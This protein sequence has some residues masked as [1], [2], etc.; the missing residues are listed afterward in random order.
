MYLIKCEMEEMILLQPYKQEL[1]LNPAT[2]HSMAN[3]KLASICKEVQ[4][5]DIN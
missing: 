5:I 2:N 3:N 4:N 1:S